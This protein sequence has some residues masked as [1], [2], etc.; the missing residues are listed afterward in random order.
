MKLI[1]PD[2]RAATLFITSF[3][4]DDLNTY[5][6]IIKIFKKISSIKF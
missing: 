4:K 1:D 3:H 6:V 5:N 2:F